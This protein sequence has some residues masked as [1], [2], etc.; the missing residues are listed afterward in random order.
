[1]R[2][3]SLLLSSPCFSWDHGVSYPPTTR[4]IYPDAFSFFPFYPLPSAPGGGTHTNGTERNCARTQR[5][6]D[7][8]GSNSRSSRV[9]STSRYIGRSVAVYRYLNRD[10]ACVEYTVMSD[11]ER[12][13][14]RV[15]ESHH[16]RRRSA[17]TTPGH[18]SE[19]AKKGKRSELSQRD[20]RGGGERGRG[21]RENS[22]G[23]KNPFWVVSIRRRE[24][25]LR[26]EPPS[27]ERRPQ[28]AVV[29]VA[30]A[31]FL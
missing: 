15:R 10:T 1:M 14:E 9:F 23:G 27:D 18:V 25:K 13:S 17:D 30:R 24:E 11:R 8:V 22:R 28:V 6:V 29:V 16:E 3:F 20:P 12:A 31:S 7:L 26:A 5:A 2:G 19:R 21:G 4:L